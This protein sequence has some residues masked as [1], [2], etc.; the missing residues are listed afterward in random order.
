MSI[1]SF[2]AGTILP[3]PNNHQDSIP[4]G[5]L[6]CDGS[7]VNRNTYSELFSLIGTTYGSGNSS[8][9]FNI[10]DLQ[11]WFVK[12]VDTSSM[13][14]SNTGAGNINDSTVHF[15]QSSYQYDLEL[16]ISDSQYTDSEGNDESS[17]IDETDP[18]KTSTT[19]GEH[20]HEYS[21]SLFEAPFGAGIG[22]DVISQQCLD[23][24]NPKNY[25]A[26]NV[27]VTARG[28]EVL[29]KISHR[30][31]GDYYGETSNY[32]GY[33][34]NP[35]N[36][37][38]KNVYANKWTH[39][40]LSNSRTYNCPQLASDLQGKAQFISGDQVNIGVDR[41]TASTDNGGD[42]NQG[43]TEDGVHKHKIAK[44][45]QVLAGKSV[46]NHGIDSY[47]FSYSSKRL[48]T[49]RDKHNHGSLI[50]QLLDSDG[51]I[52]EESDDSSNGVFHGSSEHQVTSSI[53]S[54]IGVAND[55]ETGESYSGPETLPKAIV[56]AFIIKT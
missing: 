12:G 36:A 41:P 30:F 20:T 25:N 1:K 42:G 18:G 50:F 7:S 53:T 2:P 48:F 35:S 23:R 37:D 38:E 5:W 9:E 22:G 26:S 13:R 33:H 55:P 16:E 24:M 45:F 34:E 14:D 56:M 49:S 17:I 19:A 39:C 4:S 11:E 29:G 32:F 43:V 51:Q 27:Q 3:F 52:V 15:Q 31:G 40:A 54:T 47:Q 21:V 10:P 8:T 6:L 46:H 28:N 44:E